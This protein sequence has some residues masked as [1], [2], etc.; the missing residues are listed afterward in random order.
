MK[1]LILALL[2]F[3]INLMNAQAFDLSIEN[4]KVNDYLKEKTTQELKN[5]IGLDNFSIYVNTMLDEKEI[6]KKFNKEESQPYQN[7]E[8]PGLLLNTEEKKKEEVNKKIDITSLLSVVTKASVT[9]EYYDPRFSK[10]LIEE[11]ASKILSYH[12]TKTPIK[13]IHFEISQSEASFIVEKPISIDFKESEFSKFWNKNYKYILLASAILLSLVAFSSSVYLKRGLSH[14]SKII[15]EKKMGG[16]QAQN[17]VPQAQHK[18][19]EASFDPKSINNLDFESYVQASNYLKT[20]ISNNLNV[21]SEIVMLKIMS[22]DY[23]TLTI[24]F[25][26]LDKEKKDQL[27]KNMPQ[28]KKIKFQEFIVS[29]GATF[30]KNENLLKQETIKVV[31]LL[32]LT[33]IAPHKINEIMVTDAIKGLTFDQIKIVTQALEERELPYFIDQIDELSLARLVHS[34][35]ISDEILR[36]ESETLEEDEFA[37]LL[38]KLTSFT[39]KKTTRLK[40]EKL[41]AL[42]ATLEHNKAELLADSIGLENR[43]RFEELFMKY[44]EEALNY[45]ESL[46]FE[47]LSLIYPMLSSKIKNEIIKSIPSLLAER[48]S[49]AKETNSEEGFFYKGE[50]YKYLRSFE[51]KVKTHDS[52]LKLVA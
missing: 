42:Y 30:L 44:K 34:G 41:E 5:S 10:E 2:F 32:K 6:Y 9:I 22:E 43:F 23:R 29:E 11:K 52:P 27:L 45:I 49:F 39:W 47:S 20:L 26:S 12:L 14:L 13:N 8:L 50:F 24:M 38:I 1:T 4:Q 28:D 33:S 36:Q 31:K 46:E 35:A 17:N 51:D 25:D 7:L 16:S 18:E 21:F 37:S 3:N 48:L 40:Q 19:F 15:Q